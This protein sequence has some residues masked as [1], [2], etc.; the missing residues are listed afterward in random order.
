MCLTVMK[1]VLVLGVLITHAR[2]IKESLPKHSS[3]QEFAQDYLVKFGY[4]SESSNTQSSALQRIDNAVSKFQAFAGLKQS[5]K[6]DD[7]TLELMSKRRCGVKDFGSESIDVDNHFI[8][9]IKH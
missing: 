8:S 9:F 1:Q 3:A 4:I 7:E 2:P 6:L 5:G